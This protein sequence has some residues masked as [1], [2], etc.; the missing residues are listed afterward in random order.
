MR[1]GRDMRRIHRLLPR[2]LGVLS[3]L[4]SFVAPPA[5]AQSATERT[6]Q[7]WVV[8]CETPAS[9][10][11]RC[12]MV[13]VVRLKGS[14]QR[15]VRVVIALAEGAQQPVAAVLLPL[16]V[17]LPAG[18]TIRVDEGEAL[19]VPIER[20]T[21]AGCEARIQIVDA[22]LK[23]LRAGTQVTYGFQDG[24][25]KDIAIPATLSGF[26]SAYAELK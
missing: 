23:Q 8:R 13:K 4:L 22:L 11:T 14:G 21:N 10:A 5:L 6:F 16:G 25:R 18:L 2:G 15:L 26:T 19:R 20:C 24:A 9:G 17:Y 1:Y 7:S 3:V 12:R